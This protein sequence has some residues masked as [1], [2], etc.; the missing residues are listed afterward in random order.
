MPIDLTS[1][2]A[3]LKGMFPRTPEEM[4][5][6]ARKAWADRAELEKTGARVRVESHLDNTGA[7]CREVGPASL[8]YDLVHHDCCNICNEQGESG[9]GEPAPT[10]APPRPTYEESMVLARL[11]RSRR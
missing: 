10:G 5:E 6:W 4:P 7:P 11:C 8:V 2:D 9:S 3:W 1:Y